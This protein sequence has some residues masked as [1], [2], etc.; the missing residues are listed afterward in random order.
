MRSVLVWADYLKEGEENICIHDVAFR[1]DGEMLAVAAGNVVQVYS[2]NDGRPLQTLRG[3]KDMVYCVS[4]GRDGESLASGSADKNVIIWGDTPFE[5][6]LKYSHSESVQRLAYNPKT[7]LLL[8]CTNVDFGLWSPEFKK[9]VYKEKVASRCCSCS[10]TNDGQYFAIGHHSGAITFW[11]KAGSM[12]KEVTKSRGFPVWCM[13]W[14]PSREDKLD[15]L[16]VCDWGQKLSYYL[17]NSKQVGKDRALNY[18]PTC[19]AHFPSGGFSIV[20]GSNK[21]VNV[22]SREGVQLGVVSE[23]E[24]W[25]WACAI[26]PGKNVNQV[27]SYFSTQ[28]DTKQLS[29][30]HDGP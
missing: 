14:N 7:A 13:A 20:G 10:W 3:H 25:P 29:K 17:L 18:D 4:W 5:G 9:S 23:M 12:V 15:V 21:K 27:A 1:P 24:E 6:K 8:S 16:T 11:T 30:L 26:R 28:I 19:V 2:A 22:L